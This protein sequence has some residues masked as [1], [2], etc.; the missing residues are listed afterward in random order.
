MSLEPL[1]L[2]LDANAAQTFDFQIKENLLFIK[3]PLQK[4]LKQKLPLSTLT[5]GSHTLRGTRTEVN[6]KGAERKTKKPVW[7]NEVNRKMGEEGL[8]LNLSAPPPAFQAFKV[9]LRLTTDRAN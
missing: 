8:S 9:D 7:A 4:L 3:S 2:L 6:V 5:A 1:W